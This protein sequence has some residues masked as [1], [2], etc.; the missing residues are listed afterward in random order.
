MGDRLILSLFAGLAVIVVGSLILFAL[1]VAPTLDPKF[2]PVLA[3][4]GLAAAIVFVVDTL[5]KRR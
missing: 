3:A 2:I 1:A 4:G 5:W